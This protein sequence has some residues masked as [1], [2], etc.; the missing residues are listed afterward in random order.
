MATLVTLVAAILIA[1]IGTWQ[2][3]TSRAVAL[4]NADETA[5]NLATALAQHAAR[6]IEGADLVLSGTIERLRG[7]PD[8]AGLKEFLQR[9]AAEL[10]QVQNLAVLS[11]DGAWLHDSVGPHGPLSSADRSYFQWHRDNP[12]G[13]VHVDLP[14]VSRYDAAPVLPVSR[15]LRGPDGRFEGVVSTTLR[16]SSF[17]DFYR[18]V[19]I[20]EQ[21]TIAL[22]ADT[23]RILLREPEASAM[24]GRDLSR[25]R[26]FAVG[27]KAGPSGVIHNP[28]SPVDGLERI[29]GFQRLDRYPLVATASMSVDEAL[30]P[31]RREATIQGSVLALATIALLVLAAGLERRQQ[32]IRASE[33]AWQDAQSLFRGLFEHSTDSLF[34]HRVG[35][36]GE[37]RLEAW[38]PAAAA[39]M[40]LPAE[41][42]MGKRPEDLL[43]PAH[44]AQ[45]RTE[46]ELAVL[47]G[48]PLRTEDHQ[49]LGGGLK[50]WEVIHVPLRDPG[51]D[52]IG[53]VFVGVRDITHLKVAEAEAREANRLLT[54]AEQVAHVGHWHID[55]PSNRLTWSEEVYRIHGLDPAA[56]QPTVDGAIERYHPDDRERVATAVRRAIEE[57]ESFAFELR[58]RR[59]DGSI[60]Q[61]LARGICQGETDAEG[62]S[63]G[64]R[65]IFGV[66]ADLTELK[67]AERALAEKS[68]L[69]E[70]ALESMDQ[71]LLMIAPDGTVP[72]ANARALELLGLP[73]ALMASRPSYRSVREHLRLTG[74]W[75]EAIEDSSHWELDEE[76]RTAD[77]R[78]ERRRADGSVIEIR[79]MPIRGGEGYVQTLTD[80]TQRH[81]AENRVR[82]SEARYR[83][84]ADHTSDLIILGD[85]EGRDSYVSPAVT[86]MLGYSLD[87]AS[88]M[89]LLSL[90]HPD[91][92]ATLATA[93]QALT[94]ENPTGSAIY[95]MQHKAGHWIWAEAALRRVDEGGEVRIIRALRDVTLRQRQAA[96]LE[97]AK[98][99]AE[100]GAR[101]KAEFLA[102][103]SHELRT[104]LTGMLGVHDLLQS[105]PSVSPSQSRL[106]A[107]AQE[108]GRSLLTIVND[109]LD[110]SKIEAG[111]L[112][113]EVVP[114][115]LRALLKSCRELTIEA[116]KGRDLAIVAQIDA[117]VPD[118]FLGDPVRIRQVLLNLSTNAIKF[119]PA[120]TVT[121]RARW[122]DGAE[123]QPRLRVDVVDTGIG[124]AA[125]TLPHL[126]ERFSQADGSIS[127]TY[128]GTGLGLAI[129]RRLVRLMGGEV[130]VES[131]LGEGS[132]FWFEIPL[133]PAQGQGAASTE[134]E[135]L[136]PA[137]QRG[138]RML[139]AEDNAINQ[140]I[141][142]A[143]L[144][145]KGHDVTIV[146][147]GAAAVAAVQAETVFDVVLMDVQMP[148]QDGLSATAAIRSW[149]REHGRRRTPIIAL[150]ANALA[151]EVER[152]SAAGMDA[153][154]AKPV[155]WTD[156]FA[157]IERL[158]R[159][160][161]PATNDRGGEPD[162]AR[163]TDVLD[164]TM[165]AMLAGVLG[166][167]RISGLLAAFQSEVE[168]RLAQLEAPGITAA[169]L[170]REAHAM[171][172][173]AG[174]LGFAALARLCR[175]IE[176]VSAHGAGLDRLPELRAAASQAIA[177]AART[178]YAKA[179]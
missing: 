63:V 72:V 69:F 52:R 115:G 16:L 92:V 158:L 164:E 70:A 93:L 131:R 178:P 125:E 156:L 165:L 53:R 155:D 103:M 34:V 130:G 46:L 151:E 13:G 166:E 148:G 66:F 160:A 89:R 37:F 19:K 100:A 61:V 107:L 159:A 106:I 126:F 135:G 112:A 12:D 142:A 75:G 146:G 49:I 27:L 76:N 3:A 56:F 6:T 133:R 68:S 140:E 137:G 94:A 110:F 5:R 120:G 138:Y 78:S 176:E 96:H 101:I 167:G 22:W 80:I 118:A 36:D 108:S 169:E 87:E 47:S 84:L 35:E 48:E 117:D 134:G 55:L 170:S 33:H 124:I 15:G 90:V 97:R 57:R 24:I 119:T 136:T 67:Q 145:R 23:G 83:L 21:G 102:N 144:R 18:Q 4:A 123:A 85:A 175:E 45:V 104:P 44:A 54:M 79:S 60:R 154:V 2:I 40:G 31:W 139:F 38:N 179:A 98:V 74:S 143:V 81:A 141:I 29:V 172:S 1:A 168:R 177:A 9:R 30:A 161:E 113:I 153:H 149:E 26:L 62:R 86:S 99:A 105:D 77:L 73:P 42:V 152:C 50:S 157:A 58:I 116:A 71:G 129:T 14:I 171:V 32:R 8:R 59:P 64:I 39:A 163:S 127:R 10:P 132:T 82:D 20:G 174:Q 95:R 88:R 7:N 114:F 111:Q 109:I 41:A 128:G 51:S 65:A 173:L 150:T 28:A 17:R 122:L 162:P 121:L 25:G 43:P 11:S 147:D 91:D